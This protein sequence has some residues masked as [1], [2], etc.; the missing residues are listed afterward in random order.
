MMCNNDIVNT[1]S[2]LNGVHYNVKFS[3]YILKVPTLRTIHTNY[4][5]VFS[6]LFAFFNCVTY[7]QISH[8]Y[9]EIKQLC[10]LNGF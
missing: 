4:T 3:T 6:I 5:F 7:Y 9:I 2:K 10:G 1:F 8:F